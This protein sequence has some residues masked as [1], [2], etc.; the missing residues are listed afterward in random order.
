MQ[1]LHYATVSILTIFLCYDICQDFLEKELLCKGSNQR[2]SS[3]LHFYA[4]LEMEFI[5]CCKNFSISFKP[6]PRIIAYR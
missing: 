1:Y 5:L 3:A 4:N 2:E 6:C